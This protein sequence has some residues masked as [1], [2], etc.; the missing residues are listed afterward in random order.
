M[1][2]IMATDAYGLFNSLLNELD[3]NY[4]EIGIFG[5]VGISNLAY[6]HKNKKL[7]GID[8]FIEDGFTSATTEVEQGKELVAVKDLALS[9]ISQ[10]SNIKLFQESSVDFNLRLDQSLINELNIGLIF[11]DG[12]H[13]Y[14]FVKN[15]YQLALKLIDKKSGYI[16]FDDINILGVEKAL[17]EFLKENETRIVEKIH[18]SLNTIIYKLDSID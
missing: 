12:N 2:G 8:P 1:Y 5:G 17:N 11:I 3:T 4:L 16:C 14:E 18:V 13:H 15:D 6:S 7:Y 9:R 10:E